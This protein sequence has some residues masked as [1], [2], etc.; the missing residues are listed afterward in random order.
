MKVVLVCAGKGGTGKTTTTAMLGLALA[1]KYK[2]GLLDLDIMGPNLPRVL[3][4][5]DY[6]IKSDEFYFYPK[7]PYMN[8]ELFSSAFMFPPGI[9]CAWTGEKRVELIRELIERIKWN[10]PDV[11]LLDAPPGSSDEILSAI[12][13]IPKIDGAVI[14]TTSK[15][16]SVDDANRILSLLRYKQITLLG[17]ITNMKNIIIGNVSIPLLDDGIDIQKTLGIDVIAEIPFKSNLCA[18]DFL[19]AAEYIAKKIGLEV[20]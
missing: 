16:E 5:H 13:Y 15:G 19:N 8:I 1:Q 9:A 12:Q 11:I 20:L 14:V 7:N 2:V 10:E 18:Q 6:T 4:V 17:A 3:G